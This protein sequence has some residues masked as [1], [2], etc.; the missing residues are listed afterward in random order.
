VKRPSKTQKKKWRDCTKE[1][2]QLVESREQAKIKIVELAERCCLVFP[3]G[4]GSNPEEYSLPKF[5]KD[6]GMHYRTLHEWYQIKTKV[7]DSL[8]SHD[9][10][11]VSWSELAKTGRKIRGRNKKLSKAAIRNELKKTKSKSRETDTIERYIVNLKGLDSFFKSKTKV[12]KCKKGDIKKVE[13]YCKRILKLIQKN[14]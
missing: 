13:N 2:K 8:D 12:S 4:N 5:A 11:Y 1:A 10:K 14:G 7:Y 3:G 9:K 6:I